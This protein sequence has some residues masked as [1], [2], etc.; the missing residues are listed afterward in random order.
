MRK[1]KTYEFKNFLFDSIMFVVTG[2]FWV[3]WIVIREVQ[4]QTR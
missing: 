3:V 4:I 1:H 2:G